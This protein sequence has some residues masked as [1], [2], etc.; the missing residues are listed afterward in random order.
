MWL[1]CPTDTIPPGLHI[2]LGLV[3]DIRNAMIKMA[4]VNIDGGGDEEK[5]KQIAVFHKEKL[6]EDSKKELEVVKEEISKQKGELAIIKNTLRP[7][8]AKMQRHQVALK[9]WEKKGD[10]QKIQFY[11][12]SLH[13]QKN[14][15][16]PHEESKAILE[17]EIKKTNAKKEDIQKEIS[18]H[19]AICRTLK[20]RISALRKERKKN[21]G[22]ADV[23]LD[24]IFQARNV[25]VKN[26][27]G[28]SVVYTAC[29]TLMDKCKDTLSAVNGDWTAPIQ[30]HNEGQE[31]VE[32]EAC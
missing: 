5:K 26:Y 17:A 11:L 29:R 23:E 28:G 32:H 2:P 25:T 21:E 19:G 10:T 8:N 9:K 4:L 18:T 31:E 12:S 7:M 13:T 14:E 3:N 1:L 15:K 16:A 27:H 22:G 30:K 24:N 6:V 20:A